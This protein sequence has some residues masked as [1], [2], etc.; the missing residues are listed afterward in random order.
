MSKRL[1]V[2][3]VYPNAEYQAILNA[4]KKHFYGTFA[5]KCMTILYAVFRPVVVA[6]QTNSVAEVRKAIQISKDQV[7]T[8]YDLALIMAT[9]D[10]SSSESTSPSSNSPAKPQDQPTPSPTPIAPLPS[11]SYQ[12]PRE[13]VESQAV[14][15]GS[16]ATSIYAGFEED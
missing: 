15:S 14:D 16:L 3:A 2:D 1:K 4:S 9:V 6:L 10:G 7:E 8:F 11:S 5:T 12:P 13:A